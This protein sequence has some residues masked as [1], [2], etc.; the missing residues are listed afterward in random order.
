MVSTTSPGGAMT[1]RRCF[2]AGVG[3]TSDSI[4]YMSPERAD[5][6]LDIQEAIRA[7]A[8]AADELRA[9]ARAQL[10]AAARR[11]AA[12]GLTQRQIADAMGR[13]QPEISRL[14]HFLPS[15][16]RGRLLARHR[17]EVLRIARSHGAR[18]VRVFGSVA[19]GT[20]TPESDIDL[21]VTLPPDTSLMA[22]ARIEHDISAVLG[23]PVDVV[24]AE[25]LR[26]SVA[27]RVAVEGVPL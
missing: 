3:L 14:L 5:G 15:T 16:P 20:A 13:S 25:A 8:Q 24:S 1:H 26:E 9:R 27:E 4:C 17:D 23:C 19:R 2:A 7:E 22:L 21:V 6:A 11:G 18:D 12:A 10:V